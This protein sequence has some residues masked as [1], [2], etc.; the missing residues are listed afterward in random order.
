MQNMVLHP[1]NL[2]VSKPWENIG[3]FYYSDLLCELEHSM[4]VVKAMLCHFSMVSHFD[5]TNAH[6][7][8]VTFQF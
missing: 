3:I 4:V 6:F 8:V 1:W 7:L 2:T 5:T